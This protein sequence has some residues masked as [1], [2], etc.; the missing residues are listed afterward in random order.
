MKKY[1]IPGMW[2]VI[3]E[4]STPDKESTHTNIATFFIS[5]FT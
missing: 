4:K 5:N 1:Y 3:S 2:I